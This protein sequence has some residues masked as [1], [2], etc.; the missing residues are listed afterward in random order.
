MKRSISAFRKHE[1]PA[2]PNGGLRTSVDRV[3]LFPSQPQLVLQSRHDFTRTMII[4][5]SNLV[6]S[7]PSCAAAALHQRIVDVEV[8]LDRARD[9][10]MQLWRGQRGGLDFFP[11]AS[12]DSGTTR[13][14]A[15]GFGDDARL[16]SSSPDS[17][18]SPLPLWLASRHSSIRCSALATRASSFSGTSGAAFDKIVIMLECTY[19]LDAP[20]SRTATPPG[21]CPPSRVRACTRHLTA[22]ITS[23]PFSP[24]R[25]SI[26]VQAVVGQLGAPAI[27]AHERILG[28]SAHVPSI[29][30]VARRCRGSMCSR[31]PPADSVRRGCAIPGENSWDG[32]SRRRPRPR[33]AAAAHRIRPASPTPVRWRVRNLIALGTP[34]ALRRARSFVHS[35]GR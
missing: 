10:L 22:S 4:K 21:P 30:A 29:P 33:C 18:P 20:A 14:A 5:P 15:T 34:A 7:Q 17:P 32:P 19:P 12:P 1:E 25:T 3:L 31:G 8:L 23:G 28:M 2:T 11:A 27:H 24:S 35:S 9:Q 13:P 26:V 16:S 6:A